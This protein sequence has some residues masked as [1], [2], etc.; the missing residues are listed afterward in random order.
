MQT[1]VGGCSEPRTIEQCQKGQIVCRTQRKGDICRYYD[2]VKNNFFSYW[3][4]F[5]NLDFH[6]VLLRTQQRDKQ[7]PS[8]T[9]VTVTE[10]TTFPS[11]EQSR[12]RKHLPLVCQSDFLWLLPCFNICHPHTATRLHGDCGTLGPAAEQS[13]A[14]PYSL[15]LTEPCK[16]KEPFSCLD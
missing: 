3:V 15:S 12:D 16:A 13:R 1:P 8:F 2:L 9:T 6:I 7:P 11:G 10:N 5:V 14:W 4:D